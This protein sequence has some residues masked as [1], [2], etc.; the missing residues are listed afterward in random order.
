MPPSPRVDLSLSLA[1]A[2]V[3]DPGPASDMEAERER[4][5]RDGGDDTLDRLPAHRRPIVLP[6]GTFTVL[7]LTEASSLPPVT[8]TNAASVDSEGPLT[9]FYVRLADTQPI[10]WL[11]PAVVEALRADN[12]AMARYRSD[13]CFAFADNDSRCAFSDAIN[14]GGVESRTEHMDRLA[15]SWHQRGLFSDQ[16]GGWRN[17]VRRR[18]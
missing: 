13:P 4:M 11:R 10:G 12:A 1:Q 16:L 9:P 18:T 6:H 17:E 2:R 7:P 14:E 8:M 15:R 5:M 3:D